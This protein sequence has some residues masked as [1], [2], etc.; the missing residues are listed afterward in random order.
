MSE[1]DFQ[2]IGHC[3]DEAANHDKVYVV[4][5]AEG[6]YYSAWGRRGKKLQFKALTKLG[7]A[8]KM[9]SQKSKKYKE[10]DN[11]LLFSLF[12]DFKEQLEEQ[13][14]MATLAGK[15]R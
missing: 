4:V 12:P 7:E 6:T 8:T 3:Y 2:F 9:I 13:L 14:V 10:V 15:I 11:F 1:L 5:W